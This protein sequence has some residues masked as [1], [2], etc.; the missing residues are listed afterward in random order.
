MSGSFLPSLSHRTMMVNLVRRSPTFPSMVTKLR[1]PDEPVTRRRAPGPHEIEL[2]ELILAGVVRQNS[3]IH[4]G[5]SCLVLMS[6]SERSTVVL[7]E[8][9]EILTR[10]NVGS[11]SFEIIGKGLRRC[12][13]I[14][15]ILKTWYRFHAIV[16]LANGTPVIPS[17]GDS[18]HLL[19]SITMRGASLIA[20]SRREFLDCVLAPPT[21]D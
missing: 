17:D 3:G 19:L 13:N 16:C 4:G 8:R 20:R 12:F 1:L 14:P 7:N 21:K 11:P 5:L 9:R 2:T 6:L 10:P 18:R 15:F